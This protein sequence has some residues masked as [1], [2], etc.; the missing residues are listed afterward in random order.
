MSSDQ[1]EHLNQF[2]IEQ[3]ED[4]RLL[5]LSVD[6]GFGRDGV[7]VQNKF[8]EADIDSAGSFH[9]QL[10]GKVLFAGRVGGEFYIARFNPNGEIDPTYGNEGYAIINGNDSFL[11]EIFVADNGDTYFSIFWQ[12]P[13]YGTFG[14]YLAKLSP[15]GTIDPQSP[16]YIIGDDGFDQEPIFL[17][18][19]SILIGSDNDISRVSSNLEEIW[20][21][22]RRELLALKN[23]RIYAKGTNEDNQGAIFRYRL[24]GQLDTTFGQNGM[25]ESDAMQLKFDNSNR[26]VVVTRPS[27]PS[28]SGTAKIQRFTL[29]GN[30]DLNFNGMGE[31]EITGYNQFKFFELQIGSANQ[32]FFV[33]GEDDLSVQKIRTNGTLDQTFGI[34]GRFVSTG[35][36]PKLS[37]VQA[38]GKLLVAGESPVSEFATEIKALRFFGNG[39]GT[40]D[41]SYG[42]NG[43]FTLPDQVNESSTKFKFEQNGAAGCFLH[44]SKRK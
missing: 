10:D 35:L 23:N 11:R 21:L 13:H 18:D 30:P 1:N 22:D 27:L 33:S 17:D 15:N 29:S 36:S 37:F 16:S 38:N 12:D 14:T 3:L 6:T 5:S 39:A 28:E 20:K 40:L 43:I 24:D 42:T 8:D 2:Q 26:L 34:G 41:P 19:G 32:V 4:R 9:E 44:S 31:V 25:I 7:L